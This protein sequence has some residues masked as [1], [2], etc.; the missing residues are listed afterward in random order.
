MEIFK[1]A[2]I[3]VTC[4]IIIIY[5][6][7]VNGELASIATV[8]AGVLLLSLTA[9][10]VA[11]FL[12]IFT[13]LGNYAELG[14][15]TIKIVIKIVGIS[16]LVEFTSDLIDD[17][18]LKSLSDKIVFAGRILILTTAFP[19]IEKLISTVTELL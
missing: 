2:A 15:F 13:V 12:S 10:Y 1:I 4:A 9:G 11:D 19:I 14:K 3:G 5:L 6:K 17:F 7:N 16:Y 8:C 18:G